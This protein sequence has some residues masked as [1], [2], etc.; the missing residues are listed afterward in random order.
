MLSKTQYDEA[1]LRAH[2]LHDGV[3]RRVAKKPGIDPS[4]VSR[5]TAGKRQS[6]EIRRALLDELRRIQSLLD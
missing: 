1:L 2:R 4:Y 3:Y 6:E 5:V